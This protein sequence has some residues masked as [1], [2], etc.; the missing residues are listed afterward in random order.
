M[1]NCSDCRFMFYLCHSLLF[2]W[3][4]SLHS[5]QIIIYRC[6]QSDAISISYVY[7]FFFSLFLFIYLF[8]L[9]STSNRWIV[10]AKWKIFYL[11]FANIFRNTESTKILYI[12]RLFHFAKFIQMFTFHRVFSLNFICFLFN[13]FLFFW[14]CK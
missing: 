6:P 8:H 5:T 9:N 7:Q 10:Q 2:L 12:I 3:N 4:W 13:L 1:K 11:I 14:Q